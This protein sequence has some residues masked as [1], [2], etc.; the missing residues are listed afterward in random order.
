MPY[1]FDVA[2][3]FVCHFLQ[4]EHFEQEDI[5]YRAEFDGVIKFCFGSVRGHQI[6][7]K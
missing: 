6:D 7:K 1:F 2:R 4:Q 3:L 5:A